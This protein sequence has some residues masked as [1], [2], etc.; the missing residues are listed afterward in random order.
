MP[1][2]WLQLRNPLPVLLGLAW[3]L[4]ADAAAARP[5]L[6]L[7]VLVLVLPGWH[8]VLTLREVV[9]LSMHQKRPAAAWKSDCSQVLQ[10]R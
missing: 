7:L 2:A 6:L 9:L 4:L 10:L 5:L 3:G 8:T 1:A